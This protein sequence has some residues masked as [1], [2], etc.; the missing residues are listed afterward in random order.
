MNNSQK[1]IRL[2]AALK[3]NIKKRKSFQ[4]KIKKKRK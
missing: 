3:K 2:E 1:I 4:K